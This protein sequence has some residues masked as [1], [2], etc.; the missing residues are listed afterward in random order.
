MM[1][2]AGNLF[3]LFTLL[4][5]VAMFLYVRCC[6]RKRW[7]WTAAF[8]LARE[9][10][11]ISVVEEILEAKE[12][13]DR[14]KT[15]PTKSDADAR[16][17]RQKFRKSVLTKLKI[18]VAAWQIASSTETVRLERRPRCTTSRTRSSCKFISHRS[19]EKP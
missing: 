10:A 14:Q 17:K 7:H 8:L 12:E 18:V 11:E 13:E 3:L 4:S 1:A 15:E 9:G 16:A 5:A 19:L 2:R 6:H